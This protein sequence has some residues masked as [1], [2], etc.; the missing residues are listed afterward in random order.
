MKNSNKWFTLVELIIVIGILSI[1]STIWFIS[2]SG[3]TIQARDTQ[4]QSD[5]SLLSN[6]IKQLSLRWF[7]LSLL[8]DTWSINRTWSGEFYFG[9]KNLSWVPEYKAWGINFDYLTDIS[10]PLFDP[11]TKTSYILWAHK[12]NYEIAATLESTKTSYIS[13]SYKK[14]TSSG[15]IAPLTGDVDMDNN[16]IELL[17]KEESIKFQV[18]DMIGT[19]GLSSREI[20]DIIWEKIYLNDVS[21]FFPIDKIRLYKNDTSLIW[22]IST[23]VWTGTDCLGG[24]ENLQSNVCPIVSES[25]FLLPYKF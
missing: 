9:G 14:R 2:Y 22:N 6:S 4:R 8:V 20:I 23:G 19:W 24:V 1:L 18:W 21:N 25:T 7:Q 10:T 13:S 15:T 5:I 12:T 16:S 11:K 3:Y 17:N